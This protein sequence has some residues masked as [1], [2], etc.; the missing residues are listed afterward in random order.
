MA[1]EI[2][3]SIVFPIVQCTA[4]PIWSQL[5]YIIFHNSNFNKLKTQLHKLEEAKQT[6]QQ[7]VNAATQKGEEIFEAVRN[8]LTEA[9]GAITEANN[10][11]NNEDNERVGCLN[12]PLPNLWIMHQLSKNSTEKAKIISEII[13]KVNESINMPLISSP[14]RLQ[15]AFSPSDR[16][17]EALQ[18][19]TLIMNE[20]MQKLKDDN[21]H[22]I[23]VYGMGGV[24]KS[25]LIEEVAWQAEHGGS[26]NAVMV[27]TVTRSPEIEKIQDQLADGLSLKLNKMSPRGR[28]RE[29]WDKIKKEEKVLV[30][31]D[32]IWEK[33]DLKEVGVPFGDQHKGCK[34]LLT[35]RDR[36]VLKKEMG[37]QTNF[38]L[39]V[40][41][42]E[43]GWN[44]FEK[45][46]S[47]VVKKQYLK[48]TA[49][50]VAGA[51]MGL[52]LLLVTVGKAL[53]N[54]EDLCAWKG[55][56]SQ[57]TKYDHEEYS[58]LENKVVEL[59]YKY[60]AS[61][62]HKSL[63]L[64]IGSHGENYVHIED[65]FVYGWG[66]GLF[67]HVETLADARNKLDKLI[68]D[69]KASSLLLEGEREW[70]RMHD[71]IREGAAKLASRVQP[72]FLKQNCTNLKEW[73]KIDQLRNLKHIF[74]NWCY[75]SMLP[76]ILECP[77]L[78]IL[79]LCSRDNYLKVPS[80]FFSRMSDLKLLD[81][82]GMMCTPSLPSSFGLLTRLRS[83][84]L[85]R[86]MLD[87]LTII[88]K[89]TS[90][91]IL[92]LEDTEIEELPE[93]IGQLTH[94]RRLNLNN[95]TRLRIIPKN[96]ISSLK[97]LE[98]LHMGSCCF[99]WE[100][101]GS[102]Q[103]NNASLG[104]LR[105]LN[106]LRSLHT[107]IQDI[108]IIPRGL[109]IFGKLE[110]YKIL[111]GDGW[112]WCWGYAG[113]SET[114]RTL[115]LNMRSTT[116]TSLDN[117]IKMLLNEVEDLSLAEVKGARNV[118]PEFNREEGFAQLNHLL[119]QNSGEILYIIDSTKWVIPFQ[120][121]LCL[122]SLVI[123]NLINLEKIYCGQVKNHIFTKLQVI[124]VE[125]CEKLKNLFS[126]SMA[127]DLP[128]LLEIEVSDCKFMTGVIVQQRDEEFG[129]HDQINLPKIHSIKLES[130]PNLISFSSKEWTKDIQSGSNLAKHKD[131]LS[132]PLI[133]FSDKVGMPN[134]E[135]LS[136]SS[137]NTL[138]LWDDIL[139][140][141]CLQNLTH[142]TV[143]SCGGL[144][145]LFSLS[146]AIS[147]EKLRYLKISDCQMMEDI[148]VNLQSALN[149]LTQEKVKF[150]SL[151]TLVV[152]HMDNLKAIYNDEL[153]SNPFSKLIKMEISYC[154]KL[155]S[156]FPSYVL[157]NLCNL[158]T[159]VVSNCAALKVIFE[160]QGLHNVS[161]ELLQL[162]VL[163]IKDC[164]VES[165]VSNS[166]MVEEHPRFV[167]PQL[168]SLTFWLLGELQSF[169]PGIHT[170]D[171]PSL[172]ILDVYYCNKLELFQSKS[173][174]FQ[175]VV[176]F[177][178]QPL[179]S[180]LKAIPRICELGL[181]SK[182]I[183]NICNDDDLYAVKYLCLQCFHN[184]LERF[185]IGFLQRFTNL[186][187][188]TV[189]CSYFTEIFSSEDVGPIM[190]LKTLSL[191]ILPELEHLCKGKSEIHP[192]LQNIET[193]RLTLCSRLTIVISSSTLQQFQNLD[194]L[195]VG[196]CSGLVNIITLVA[197]RTFLKLRKLVIYN[198]EKVEEI[199]AREDDS[200]GSEIVFMKLEHLE[201]KN[202]PALT[203]FCKENFI[204]KFPLLQTLHVMGCPRMETFTHGNLITTKLTKVRVTEAADDAWRWEGE[205][206][207][208]IRKMFDE[209]VSQ[210]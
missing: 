111:I 121:F 207:T 69:L 75:I 62:L 135:T 169:Y 80:H 65:L 197:E 133:L 178:G 19:R 141:S 87:D 37:T 72:T 150:P 68:Y 124:K 115:K 77:K 199:V 44:L 107:Q 139:I 188:L 162:Q 73:P 193:L 10:F 84:G 94:L 163:E 194:E 190:N 47:D 51:C 76:E 21:M 22:V 25:T 118:L 58:S 149:P 82:G 179:F 93:E 67:E 20:I 130:L 166:E 137:I 15:V 185:P 79:L 41:Y 152:S 16:G 142:L 147:L 30:I 209:S 5:S 158:E 85:Y 128:Q 126:F 196:K 7:R 81:L 66:V 191:H 192:I 200:D 100:V 59:S 177:H 95:C 201:L 112:K 189:A 161:M 24:G 114:L 92:S 31:M 33:I 195:C 70:V 151:E 57:L 18:S 120:S 117:G 167:F 184:E 157:N 48:P 125:G 9:G 23:G 1:M 131:N 122:E 39:N 127:A 116:M 13:T 102:E 106:H 171:C 78:E 153:A 71:V 210:C 2:V 60:L 98:E 140:P 11:L 205:L 203:S 38:R 12:G 134:L 14:P 180:S 103:C 181:R 90:L 29:L 136:L 88:S 3:K 129:D 182:D 155:P 143:D 144:K 43:E 113:Y 206:N 176:S 154:Q 170:L 165:I 61:S 46:T 138:K 63:F 86:C 208:T 159:L 36:N 164:G 8:I 160:T 28:A 35:S 99:K 145:Y 96:I 105:E 198:C 56:L 110:K 53:K 89:L 187:N 54:E 49:L 168:T 27:A 32:D 91:E 104:E 174:N 34:L 175:E 74:L 26:F 83:L 108:S 4:G 186:D 40:L 97:Y 148:F 202:L 109:L 204:F 6:L 101:E 52:P 45:A 64:L 173:Q 172:E 55:V 123:L 132:N 146:M 17:Y 183:T 50:E 42:E 119:I 156:I